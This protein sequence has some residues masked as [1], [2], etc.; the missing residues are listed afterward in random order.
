MSMD[1]ED[2][3]QLLRGELV[4]APKSVT[5]TVK[6]NL[7]FFFPHMRTLVFA[8]ADELLLWC[9][10]EGAEYVDMHSIKRTAYLPTSSWISSATAGTL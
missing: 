4:P 5:S 10:P 8:D 9:S 2:P 1:S 3:M 7:L 6:G